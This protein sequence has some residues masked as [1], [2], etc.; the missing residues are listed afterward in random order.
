MAGTLNGWSGMN[1][2]YGI[3]SST[4]P[5]VP[6]TRALRRN[7]RSANMARSSRATSV[8]GCSAMPRPQVRLIS[9]LESE[10]PYVSMLTMSNAQR[11]DCMGVTA[12]EMHVAIHLTKTNEQTNK[13]KDP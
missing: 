13:Q 2:K 4:A 3:D 12:V 6:Q 1:G 8:G 11:H 7:W 10:L 9:K 5:H